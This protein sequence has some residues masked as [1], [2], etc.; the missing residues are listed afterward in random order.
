MS[1]IAKYVALSEAD[2]QAVIAQPSLAQNLF[3]SIRRTGALQAVGGRP[4]LRV[5]GAEPPSQ[6]AP[7]AQLSLDKAWH[8]VHYLLCGRAEEAPGDL[9][10][11]V[12][13]GRALGSDPQGFSGY[14]P[15]RY[16]KPTDVDVISAVLNDP[17][18]VRN[19]EARFD[20]DKM[21]ELGIYPG[22]DDEEDE[23]R[24]WV[25]DALRDLCGF[26]AAASR[27]RLAIV[28]CIV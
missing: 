20:C 23:G 27:D 13:G 22:W 3:L 17:A 7:R 9:A 1:M 12:M 10:K 28:T 4:Q 25:L 26:Y 6:I 24:D 15:A 14:G 18:V 19:A 21:D 5:V 8:G 11:A 2:L 16:F